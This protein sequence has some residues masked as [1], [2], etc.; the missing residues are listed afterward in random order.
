MFVKQKL[1]SFFVIITYR[2][3]HY[4]LQPRARVRAHTD[5]HE[6]GLYKAG[7]SGLEP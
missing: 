1:S 4:T 6:H 2:I 3:R 7:Q 5:T